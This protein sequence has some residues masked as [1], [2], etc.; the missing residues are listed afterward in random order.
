MTSL[1]VAPDGCDGWLYGGRIE[2][3][4]SVHPNSSED[5]VSQH[6]RCEEQRQRHQ[7]LNDPRPRAHADHHLKSPHE[8]QRHHEH[9]ED[10]GDDG[11]GVQSAGHR[12]G[13][14]E[15]PERREADRQEEMPPQ[16]D[17][18]AK[19]HREYDAVRR[20]TPPFTCERP[21]QRRAAS[22]LLLML[23]ASNCDGFLGHRARQVQASYAALESGGGTSRSSQV[24]SKS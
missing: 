7:E 20:I 17:S 8:P 12:L 4:G 18:H 1:N 22:R 3:G 15:Q 24:G 14:E 11:R 5:P 13:E 10:L 6:V 2:T 16:P 9:S 19:T 23:K 21:T